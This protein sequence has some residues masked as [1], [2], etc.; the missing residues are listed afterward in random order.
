MNS[1]C[2]LPVYILNVYKV[3]PNYCRVLFRF[4]S[5]INTL[6]ARTGQ[7]EG[8][9]NDNGSEYPKSAGKGLERLEKML[10][11][12]SRRFDL[13]GRQ[14]IF[15]GSEKII[16][17]EQMARRRSFGGSGKR[18]IKTKHKSTIRG[19]GKREITTRSIS[20]LVFL[21]PQCAFSFHHY[22]LSPLHSSSSFLYLFITE[23]HVGTILETVKPKKNLEKTCDNIHYIY[24]Q[25]QPI[26]D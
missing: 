5:A 15:A 23:K 6:Y 16:S 7:G 22:I 13:L 17:A 14:E 8:G 2:S 24:K 1:T 18:N 9:T 25:I 4:A 12:Q 19:L 3:K 21:L 20:S 26:F 10:S 11:C